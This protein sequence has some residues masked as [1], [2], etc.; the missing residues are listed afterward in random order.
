KT[1]K[2]T[3]DARY[4]TYPAFTPEGRI[5]YVRLNESWTDHDVILMNADGSNP[6]V[7]LSDN[8]LFDYHYGR[9]FNYPSVSPDGSQFIFKSYRSGWLNIWLA[10]LDGSNPRQIAPAAADQSDAAWSPDGRSIAYVENHDG[11]L[12]LRVVDTKCGEPRVVVAP[13]V[14][15]CH[16]PAWSPDGTRLSYLFGSVTSPNDVF[17]VNVETGSQTRPPHSMLG[18][19]CARR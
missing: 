2:L 16:G 19:G 18:R 11:T 5:L 7:V 9:T 10:S 3:G 6:H 15:V 13:G 1:R 17:V 12:D 8:D 14:G 4:E